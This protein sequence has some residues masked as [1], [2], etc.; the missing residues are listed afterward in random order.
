[1]S[2]PSTGPIDLTP[3]PTDGPAHQTPAAPP[4]VPDAS[5]PQPPAR[6]KDEPAR[7]SRARPREPEVDLAGLRRRRRPAAAQL[8]HRVAPELKDALDRTA[9]A[10]GV[11]SVELLEALLSELDPDSHA[12]LAEAHARVLSHFAADWPAATP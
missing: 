11:A 1:M 4:A 5:P 7:P 12:G 10:L 2:A 6:S 3:W 9:A 8:N